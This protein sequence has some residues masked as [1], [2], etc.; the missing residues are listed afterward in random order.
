[1]IGVYARNVQAA[2]VQGIAVVREQGVPELT[3]NG[4]ALVVPH[5]VVTTYARPLERVLLDPSRDANPFFHLLESI[6]ML[7]GRDD[8]ASLAPYNAGLKNYSDD[9]VTYHGAYGWR[10]RSHFSDGKDDLDQLARIIE[11][12]RTNPQ[13]RRVVL[14]MW[15]PAVD[16]GQEGADFPCNTQVYFR[17]RRVPD[18]YTYLD[19]TV[20]CRSNDAIWGAYGANAV[21]FS[22][23]HEFVAAA[24][25]FQV[26]ILHQL[27]NNLHAYDEAL[28]KVGEPCWP[29]TWAKGGN[30][31]R[32][33]R[34]VPLAERM[35]GQHDDYTAHEIRA[36]PLFQPHRDMPVADALRCVEDV[37]SGLMDS[38]AVRQLFT[39][40][41][42]DTIVKMRSA[43][44]SFKKKDRDRALG[45]C[46][47][48]PGTD[49]S[50][51]CVEWLERRYAAG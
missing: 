5:P 15:D 25:G 19:M 12:L 50:R 39:P 34:S 38:E 31:Y 14:S 6:W 42:I 3:R 21:H 29:V 7:A 17:T 37:W 30:M 11:L 9:G 8:V 33:V 35:D 44:H 16:L 48:I 26:G 36:T 18:D 24:C 10:W 22:V 51:A 1:M 49:W 28:E 20:M 46:R 27:S 32:Y 41:G 4:T 23:L 47:D 2:Y 13:D 45:L 43:Y 40:G